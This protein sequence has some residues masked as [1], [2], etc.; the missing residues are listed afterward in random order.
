MCGFAGF[1]GCGT[2]ET[3]SR[4]VETLKHRGPDDN[5]LLISKDEAVANGVYLGH[6]RLAILN[7]N[8]GKQPLVDEKTKAALVYDGKIYNHKE[9]RSELEGL[10]HV[11]VTSHSDAETALR[12]FLEWGPACFKK[13]NG[14]FAL[15]IHIPAR[16]QL[17]LARDRFG[18]KPLFYAKSANGFGFASEIGTLALWDGFDFSI[19]YGNLQRYFAWGYMPGGRTLYRNCY[20]LLPGSWLCMDLKTGEERSGRYYF[21]T[22]NPDHS[23]TEKRE[24]ALVDELQ[25]LLVQAVSRCLVSD[26]PPG[27]FLSGGIDSS[28]ILAAAARI[29]PPNQ[30]DAFTMGFTDP[31]F[32]ESPNAK[33]VAKAFG[34]R[35]HVTYLTID[36]LQ[37]E[38]LSILSRMSEPLGDASLIPTK[39]L[40]AFTRQK[41]AVALSGDGGDE[42]FAGYDP[43]LALNPALL[44]KRFMPGIA[45]RGIKRAVQVLPVSD[46]NMSL[47]FKLK[48]FLRGLDYPASMRL[49]VWL[50]P[51]SPR[52]IADIFEVPLTAEELY[53][54][55]LTLWEKN[56]HYDTMQHA[57]MFFTHFY[58]PYGCSVKVDRATM[59]A[60][61][62]SRAVFLDNDLVTFCERL[63]DHFKLRNGTRKYI[64]KKALHGWLPESVICLPKK[65]FG[66]P[67]SRW[68]REMNRQPSVEYG[69]RNTVVQNIHTAHL[70]RKGDH[71]LFLWSLFALQALPTKSIPQ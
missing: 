64:L 22:L 38:A 45:H 2:Q 6:S 10:G 33:L 9:I 1:W 14:M 65:G 5:A 69:M 3:L 25:A 54:D 35:H 71:R 19:N 53:E 20:G 51:L 50:G 49:P 21:F 32:D 37:N 29:L 61:L 66:I 40:S 8:C 43:F 23:M 56:P 70:Q 60:S 58:L 59:M 41:V 44:Y 7:A 62:E 31:S 12:A 4:M 36:H 24:P 17:W 67:L 18:Q 57:L 47:E 15:A 26:V 13:F 63:P 46:K 39:T 16:H 28:A 42:L 68:L 52:E 55:A 30:I 11:F 27:I 34:V 48:R